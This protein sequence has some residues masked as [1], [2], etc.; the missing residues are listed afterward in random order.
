MA[1]KFE[2]EKEIA[3]LQ[4]KRTSDGFR[5]ELNLVSF[6]DKKGKY[7]IRSWNENHEEMKKGIQLSKDEIVALKDALNKLNLE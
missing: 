5:L 7:D 6:N 4:E 3:P 1:F 2:V